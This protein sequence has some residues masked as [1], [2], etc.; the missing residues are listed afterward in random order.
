MWKDCQDQLRHIPAASPKVVTL[1]ASLSSA[2]LPSLEEFL[3]ECGEEAELRGSYSH[4]DIM[5]GIG[6]WSYEG[7][8]KDDE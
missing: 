5:K 6:Y 4:E 1:V 7:Y 2:R 8:A 3:D